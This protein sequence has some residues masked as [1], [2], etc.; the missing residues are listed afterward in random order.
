M[1]AS[2]LTIAILIISAIPTFAQSRTNR[3]Y[4]PCPSSTTPASV[5]IS[6]LGAIALTPCSGQSLTVG[7]ANV[8]LLSLGEFNNYLDI[9]D[10]DTFTIGGISGGLG[11]MLTVNRFT[12]TLGMAAVTMDWAP[13]GPITWKLRRTVTT[14]GTTGDQTINLMNGTVNFAAAASS[15]TVTNST[16]NASSIVLATARTNDSTCSV[17]NVVSG[18]GS[19]VINMTAGCTAETSVGFLVLN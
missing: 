18:A 11:S 19:F 1:K 9:P 8:G 5:T 10:G 6:T 15:L 2:L 7:V 3:I 4:R 16:V 17:K 13:N 12:N 14:G